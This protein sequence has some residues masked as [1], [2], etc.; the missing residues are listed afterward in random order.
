MKQE[1]KTETGHWDIDNAAFTHVTASFNWNKTANENF[2][3]MKPL[4]NFQK[5]PHNLIFLG[6]EARPA[7]KADNLTAIYEP[8]V[9]VMW[10]P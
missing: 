5:P 4:R 6:S 2:E 9:K 7:H 3:E 10:D 8:I 1:V